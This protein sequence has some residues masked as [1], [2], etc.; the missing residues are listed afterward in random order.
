ML[1][2][3]TG[4][5]GHF[6]VNLVRSLLVRG[7]LVC[8]LIHKNKQTLAGL[9]I[10]IVPGDARDSASLCPA[11]NGAAVVYHLVARILILIDEWPLLEHVNVIGTR[12]LV[13]TSLDCG[14]RRLV[15]FSSIHALVQ[16][17][18]DKPVVELRPFRDTIADTLHWFQETGQLK[19]LLPPYPM[20]PP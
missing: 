7:R 14:V 1:T 17:P 16:E 15:H 3:V 18:L 13:N 12:N 6:G 8:A 19:R 9:D 11:F 10:E 2:L 20:G 4:A 5:S